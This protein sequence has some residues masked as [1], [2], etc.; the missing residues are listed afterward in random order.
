MRTPLFAMIG[1]TV[2]VG[3]VARADDWLCLEAEAFADVQAERHNFRG[4]GGVSFPRKESLIRT[5][6]EVSKAIEAEVWARV[7]FPWGGQDALTLTLDG[8]EF[9]VTARTTGGEGGGISATSRS[10]IG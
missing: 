6:V 7:Y 4:V 8:K 2:L 9:P 5:S 1:V 10:G 3:G